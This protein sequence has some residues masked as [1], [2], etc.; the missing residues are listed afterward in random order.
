MAPPVDPKSLE[1]QLLARGFKPDELAEPEGMPEQLV[2]SACATPGISYPDL[3]RE[4]WFARQ[5]RR[6]TLAF[7]RLKRTGRID[8]GHGFGEVWIA[9]E[10]IEQKKVME[11]AVAEA[12]KKAASMAVAL[13][14]P[15]A[16]K[17]RSLF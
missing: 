8:F 14:K 2:L 13:S 1:T 9:V 6:C 7:E 5:P 15:P 17:Q 10:A 3:M 12:A 16:V 4:P 11:A